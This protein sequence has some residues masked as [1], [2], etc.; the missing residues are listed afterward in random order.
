MATETIT[1][2]I[3]K[4]SITAYRELGESQND[5]LIP[6]EVTSAQ[7]LEERLTATEDPTGVGVPLRKEA[8][9]A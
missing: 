9:P 8:F 6:A 5:L 2:G 1:V 7:V 4:E 3:V